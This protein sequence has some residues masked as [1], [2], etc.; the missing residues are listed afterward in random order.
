MTCKR[1]ATRKGLKGTLQR[2]RKTVHKAQVSNLGRYRNMHGVV[3]TPR[4]R[5]SGY[6]SVMVNNKSY[7]LHRLVA[8]AFLGTIK[9]TDQTTV[10][11]ID[12]N[13]GNNRVENLEWASPGEQAQHSH[14][15]NENRVSCAPK[16]SKPVCGRKLVTDQHGVDAQPVEWISYASAAEAA[17]ELGL[18]HGNIRSCCRGKRKQTKGYEFKYDTP[19]EPELLPG[20]KWYDVIV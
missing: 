8:A 9:R 4:A 11:H 14:A 15:T 12:R 1:R 17:R 13:P 19:T 2:V 10:N 20:E 7:Q 5:P 18:N 6:V 16:Q 3:T